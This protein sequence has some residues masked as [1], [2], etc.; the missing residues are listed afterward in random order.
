MAHF[1]GELQGNRS[2]TFRLGSRLSGIKSHVHGWED[3]VRVVAKVDEIIGENVYYIYKTYGSNSTRKD[4]L[5]T[6]VRP[7]TDSNGNIIINNI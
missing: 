6:I 3:G 4:E 5:V 2:E 7:S 1:K